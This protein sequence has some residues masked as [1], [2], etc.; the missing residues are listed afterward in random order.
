MSEAITA[1]A[2]DPTLM[3]VQDVC[4]LFHRTDRTIR[5]WIK[6]GHLHPV[7][8][9]RSVFFRRSEVDALIAGAAGLGPVPAPSGP[10]MD[11]SAAECLSRNAERG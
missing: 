7:R 4:R 8:V 9:G 1:L 10:L 5:N 6:R 3:S 2:A 11:E